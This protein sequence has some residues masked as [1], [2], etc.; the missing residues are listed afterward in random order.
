VT[1]TV[2]ERI[3]IPN[4]ITPNGDGTNDT[5]ELPGIEHYPNAEVRIFNRWGSEL[6]YSKGYSRP[7]DGNRNGSRLPAATYYYVIQ[8]NNGRP[9]ISGSLTIIL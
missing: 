1:V 8:P 5:W 7:F 2:W 3:T 4:G 9:T 6:F